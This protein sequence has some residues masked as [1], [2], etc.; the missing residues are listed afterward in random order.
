MIWL[1]WRQQRS[2]TLLAAA[3]LVLLTAIVV[4]VGIHVASLYDA[5]HVAACLRSTSEACHQAISDFGGRSGALGS[6]LGWFTLFPGLLGVALAAPIVLDLESGTATFAWTQGVTRTRWLATR[7]SLAV[8]TALVAGG[9]LTLLLTWY[10][11][12]LDAVFGRFG[13]GVYDVEGTV[14]LAYVLFALG[15]GLAVGVVWR[16]TALSLVV[17]FLG[18]VGP[19]LFVDS[20]LRQRFESPLGV[21]WGLHTPEPALKGAWILWSGPSDQ[22]GH[23]F[24]GGFQALEACARLVGPGIRSLDPACLARHGAGFNHAIYQPASRFWEF[25]GIETGLFG[26]VALLLLGFAVWWLLVRTD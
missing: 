12:P 20:W 22:A 11:G 8:G 25:Q 10:R 19:R 14:P 21:T 15:L 2:E 1:S 9:A 17:A 5:D 13:S 6:A 18:Y 26:G 23:P 3:L 24:S 16:R 4:P 7:L